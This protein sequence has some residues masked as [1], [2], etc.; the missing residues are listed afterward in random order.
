MKA[1][2]LAFAGLFFFSL[3]AGGQQ[4]DAHPVR[5]GLRELNKHPNPADIPPLANHHSQ[6]SSL[7]IEKL[8]SDAE[9]LAKLSRSIPSQID[10]VARGQLPKDFGPQLKR[11]EKLAKRLRREIC[12]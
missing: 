3:V 10:L 11:I 5:P 9:E 12:P 1:L 8:K 4:S 6:K 7:D 2:I